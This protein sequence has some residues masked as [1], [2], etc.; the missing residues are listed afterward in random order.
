MDLSVKSHLAMASLALLMGFQLAGLVL[1]PNVLPQGTNDMN[2]IIK[3]NTWEISGCS[4]H[5]LNAP[6]SSSSHNRISSSG[7]DILNFQTLI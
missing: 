2:S 3:L 5:C 7:S 6:V 4:L 1:L